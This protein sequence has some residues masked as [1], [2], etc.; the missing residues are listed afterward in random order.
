[1]QCDGPESAVIR[2]LVPAARTTAADGDSMA[3]GVPEH[4]RPARL[5]NPASIESVLRKKNRPRTMRNELRRQRERMN[6]NT[7]HTARD[8]PGS[9]GHPK[10][11]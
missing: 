9:E 1:M 4:Y 10:P 2:R 5:G 7:S 3:P 11:F 8:E 6:A